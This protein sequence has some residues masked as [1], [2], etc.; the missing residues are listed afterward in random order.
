MWFR[1]VLSNIEEATTEIQ[2]EE[3]LEEG[4]PFADCADCPT[5]DTPS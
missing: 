3:H 1:P 2:S 5:V 4:P